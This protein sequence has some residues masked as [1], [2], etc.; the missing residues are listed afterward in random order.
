VR[1]LPVFGP[2]ARAARI[3]SSKVFA[4]QLFERYG[5]PTAKFRAFTEIESA[6]AYVLENG[7]PIVVKASGLAAGKG[8]VVCVSVP[9]A[10]ATLDE[11]LG[12]HSF[13]EAGS[14]VV[15]EE[16]MSG[17]E[18]SVFALCDGRRAIPMLPAQDHKRI[19]EGDTGPNTGGMGAYAPVSIATDVLLREITD[20]I[21]NPTLSALAQEGCPFHGLLYAGLMLTPEGPKVIEYNC[22][23]GDPETQALLPLMESSL[24]DPMLAIANGD[25]LDDWAESGLRWRAGAAV[26]TVLASAGYPGAYETG[27]AITIPS[28]LEEADDLVVFHAGTVSRDGAVL[29]TGGRVLAVTGL[30]A[31]VAIAA[32]RSRDAASSI[33]F[34]GAQFRRDIAWR[35]IARNR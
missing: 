30:G 22:R 10:L 7:A 25:G 8:A 35:E 1:S 26:T 15:I 6:R 21:L 33:Q 27:A 2:D 4:K 12:Q 32:A 9:E 18:L 5:I 14:E 29:S 11:M 20:T 23:F 16:F 19:G 24:L 3:E 31:D 34:A 17:E 13:G 28:G